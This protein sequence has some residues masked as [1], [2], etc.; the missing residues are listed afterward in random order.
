M[1]RRVGSDW[2]A[3]TPLQAL[4][5]P[6]PPSEPDV[7]V[8]THPA[9]HEFMPSGYAMILV[10]S[11]MVSRCWPPGSGNGLPGPSAVGTSRPRSRWDAIMVGSAGAGQPISRVSLADPADHP[12]PGVLVEVAERRF[13][14]AV[15]E[16][17]APAPQRRIELAQQGGQRP[18]R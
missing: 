11:P 15:A 16:V 8:S 14:H 7:P 5:F 17:G 3:L 12:M 9:L 6:S 1:C 4:R 13:R 18:M 10:C 2:G